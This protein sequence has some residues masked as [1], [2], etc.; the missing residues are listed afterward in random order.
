MLFVQA[1]EA[2]AARIGAP[3]SL[4]IES[5]MPQQSLYILALAAAAGIFMLL[6]SGC[7]DTSSTP[8][9]PQDGRLHPHTD[10]IPRY[11]VETHQVTK[12]ETTQVP[13]LS[14][15]LTNP[16]QHEAD[17]RSTGIYLRRP[18]TVDVAPLSRNRMVVLDKTDFLL[19]VYHIETAQVDTVAVNDGAPRN[20][21]NATG[22]D[23]HADTVYVSTMDYRLQRFDCS[24]ACSYVD[25]QT[26]DFS[27]TGV[28]AREARVSLLGFVY[29]ANQENHGML[30]E[31][32]HRMDGSDI[33]YRFM[34]AYNSANPFVDFELNEGFVSH[35]REYDVFAFHHMPYLYVFE[36]G[37]AVAMFEIDDFYFEDR[38]EMVDPLGISIPTAPIISGVFWAYNYSDHEIIIIVKTRDRGWRGASEAPAHIDP[39]DISERLEYYIF[40]A[41]SMTLSFAGSTTF[42]AEGGAHILPHEDHVVYIHEGEVKYLVN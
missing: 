24:A 14:A 37:E 36:E 20:V 26:L 30:N 34:D 18:M 16:G 6:L 9:E 31:I 13:D 40:D 22:L 3:R 32:G 8:A 27:V 41:S 29:D 10:L 5:M 28:A 17:L 12:D 23:V 7:A 15:Y 33:E 1:D 21:A 35:A 19:L 38:E 39:E 2:R 4:A 25:T 42:G 11:D